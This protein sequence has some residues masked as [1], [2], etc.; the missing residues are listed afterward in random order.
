MTSQ[1]LVGHE[2]VHVEVLAVHQVVLNAIARQ[3]D[4]PLVLPDRQETIAFSSLKSPALDK[5][6]LRLKVWPELPHQLK[7]SRHLRF[8][9]D[10]ANIWQGWHR[11]SPIRR[12][13]HDAPT[14]RRHLPSSFPAACGR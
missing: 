5:M 14:T 6:L 4:R 11:R 10:E 2:V 9:I 3:G 8:G 7:A 12:R 13:S 1:R